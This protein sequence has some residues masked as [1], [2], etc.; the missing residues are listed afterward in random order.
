[1]RPLTCFIAAGMLAVSA[2]PSRASAATAY[3]EAFDTLYKIDLDEAR[4]TELGQTGYY[5]GSRLGNVS[6]LSMDANGA[7]YAVV[8]GLNKLLVRIDPT[9]GGTNVIGNL[10]LDG[11][12]SGQYDSLDLNMTAGCDNT[13]WLS[14]AIANKLWKVDPGTGAAT[15]VGAT[16]RTITGLVARGDRL[17]GAGG[18]GDNTFYRIDPATGAATPIGPFGPAVTRWVNSVSMGFDASGTLWAVINYMPPENDSKPAVDWADLATINPATGAV[19][20][21]RPIQGPESLRQIGMKGFTV[22]PPQCAR[23]AEAQ[24]APVGSPWTLALLGLLLAGVGLGGMRRAT[25]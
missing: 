11:Q 15:P 9:N 25:R 16:G 24:P 1:M 14:S 4:A 23:A 2:L 8:G 3:G 13:L 10:G 18:K 19:T 12:G 17:Y 6:G 22:G 5:R 20:L 7:L 21:L